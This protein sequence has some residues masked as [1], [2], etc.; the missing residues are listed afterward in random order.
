MAESLETLLCAIYAVEQKSLEI[1][2]EQMKF[3]V[4]EGIRKRLKGHLA[5]T[6]W[7]IKLLEACIKFQDIDGNITDRRMYRLADEIGNA[8][9][10]E[11]KNVEIDLYKK[12]IVAAR[13]RHAPEV[14]QACREIL[15]Q[16]RAM[17]EWIEDNSLDVNVS[18]LEEKRA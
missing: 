10:L 13:E 15:E 7:Q 4:N 5:E 11:I 16:E 12:L 6:Q 8:S 3:A 2:A 14:L 1:I 18:F 17:A 9:L